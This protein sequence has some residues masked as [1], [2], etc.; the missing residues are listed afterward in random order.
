MV[1]T[2]AILGPSDETDGRAG[3]DCFSLLDGVAGVLMG[4]P[5]NQA[6]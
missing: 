1:A 4:L 6:R 3:E 5:A 2:R